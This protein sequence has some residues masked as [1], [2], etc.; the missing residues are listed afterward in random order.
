MFHTVAGCE[1]EKERTGWIWFDPLDAAA[2]LQILIR[3]GRVEDRQRHLWGVVD[4]AQ[5]RAPGR[6]REAE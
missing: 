1:F 5:L 2:D 4:V 6:M 3:V